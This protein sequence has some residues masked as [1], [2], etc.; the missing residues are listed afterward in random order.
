MEEYVRPEMM[1]FSQVYEAGA[2]MGGL[3]VPV[4]AY[5]VYWVGCIS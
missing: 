5:V 4:V 1:H 2:D 3:V